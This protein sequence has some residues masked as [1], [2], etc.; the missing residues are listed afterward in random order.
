MSNTELLI[1]GLAIAVIIYQYNKEEP[2]AKVVKKSQKKLAEQEP[3]DTTLLERR[4]A[5]RL[6]RERGRRIAH[7]ADMARRIGHAADMAELH[8]QHQQNLADIQEGHEGDMAVVELEGAWDD[9]EWETR[10]LRK[11]GAP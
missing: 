8:Q 6:E 7:A 5:A 10:H 4:E 11:A 3:T 2:K 1:A 9:M